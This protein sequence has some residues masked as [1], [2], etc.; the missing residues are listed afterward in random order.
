[1]PRLVRPR[2]KIQLQS[3]G[4]F[5]LDEYIHAVMFS[6]DG[7]R[8]AAK[9]RCGMWDPGGVSSVTRNIKARYWRRDGIPEEK[10][11]QPPGKTEWGV[12]GTLVPEKSVP[13][14]RLEMERAGRSIWRGSPAANGWR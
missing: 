5:Q 12:C 4:T 1:M 9:S 2:A 3:I 8:L 10:F 14:F 7:S 11:S 13:W 6:P